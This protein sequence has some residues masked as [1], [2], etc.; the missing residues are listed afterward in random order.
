M[1][2]STNDEWQTCM[3]QHL[4]ILGNVCSTSGRIEL[5]VCNGT[6]HAYCSAISCAHIAFGG[7]QESFSHHIR[8]IVSTENKKNEDQN[9][10]LFFFQNHTRAQNI[11]AF[12]FQRL[13]SQ[14]MKLNAFN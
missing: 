10:F 4:Y 11:Y 14:E 6:L 8:A 9:V 1:V 13:F 3:P 2:D 12:H 5:V 7:V